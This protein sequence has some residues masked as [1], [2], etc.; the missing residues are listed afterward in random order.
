LGTIADEASLTIDDGAPA[1]EVGAS[2]SFEVESPSGST[3]TVK[4]AVTTTFRIEGARPTF[5]ITREE[6]ENVLA[7]TA[8]IVTA[9]AIT[10]A[11][12]RRRPI[13]AAP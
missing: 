4:Y 2:T 6:V 12:T 7:V 11:T 9:L 3:V 10:K 5:Q 8:G 13:P 1:F